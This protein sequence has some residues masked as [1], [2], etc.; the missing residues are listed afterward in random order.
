MIPPFQATKY[1]YSPMARIYR[2]TERTTEERAEI[3]A[4]RNASITGDTTGERISSQ[5]YN[6]VLR[7]IA[8][9]RSRREELGLSQASLAERLGIEPS[10]LCRLETFKVVNPTIWT[11]MHWA[12]ALDCSLGFDLGVNP[13]STTKAEV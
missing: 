6:A 11:L 8:A 7:L 3:Q 1:K 4:I 5:N 10:A 9:L 2:N 13:K 12:D